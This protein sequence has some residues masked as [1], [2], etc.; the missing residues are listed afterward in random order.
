M[1]QGTPANVHD[2]TFACLINGGERCISAAGCEIPDG[3]PH[4]NLRA[5]AQALKEFGAPGSS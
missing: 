5:Q 1:L 3:T 4:E 2:A